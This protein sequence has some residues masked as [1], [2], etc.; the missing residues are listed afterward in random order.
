MSYPLPKYDG[1]Y[2]YRYLLSKPPPVPANAIKLIGQ[3]MEKRCLLRLF[4]LI[5]FDF[6]ACKTDRVWLLL[7]QLREIFE[8]ACGP[9]ISKTQVGYLDATVKAYLHNRKDYFPHKNLIPKHH[10]LAHYSQ[11]ILQFGP[12]VRL[13]TMRLENKHS[14]F[15][16]AMP[17]VHNF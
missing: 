11:L 4:P 15:K 17:S 8:L 10:F 5:V 9:T 1:H 14:F 2:R 3:A 7:L 12:L 16:K 6:I 13:W